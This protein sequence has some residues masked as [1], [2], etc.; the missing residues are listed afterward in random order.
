MDV[1]NQLP[2]NNKPLETITREKSR[3]TKNITDIIND[4]IIDI[5]KKA[6]KTNKNTNN[7]NSVEIIEEIQEKDR[8]KPQEIKFTK[9]K[10]SEFDFTE[11]MSKF[12]CSQLSLLDFFQLSPAARRMVADG[13]KTIPKSYI[14]RLCAVDPSMQLLLIATNHHKYIGENDNIL[15]NDKTQNIGTYERSNTHEGDTLNLYLSKIAK[16]ST[17]T[18]TIKTSINNKHVISH[19]DSGACIIAIKNQWIESV[20]IRKTQQHSRIGLRMATGSSPIIAGEVHDLICKFGNITCT[21]GALV[22]ESLD[23]DVLLGR[24][25]LELVRAISVCESSIYHMVY[26]Y[27]WVIVDGSTGTVT[28]QRKLLP[29]EDSEWSMGHLPRSKQKPIVKSTGKRIPENNA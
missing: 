25:F 27:N 5:K 22:V 2:D 12:M 8:Y 9:N 15:E 4:K 24:P 3:K 1:D 26:D 6:I 21:F 13:L 17:P 14:N 29:H 20:G 28:N 16:S 19:I 11:F 18:H 10:Q 23:C 7:N